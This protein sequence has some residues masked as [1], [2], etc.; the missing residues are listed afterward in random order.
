MYDAVIAGAGPA[1][2]TFAGKL[3]EAGYK[4]LLVDLNKKKNIG[5]KICGDALSVN[6]LNFL[7]NNFG[8]KLTKEVIKTDINNSRIFSS[9]FKYSELKSGNIG[10]SVISREILGQE[11]INN[12]IDKG[13]ELLDSTSVLDFI[14]KNNKI[15]GIK[16]SNPKKKEIKAELIIDATGVSS[17]LRKNLPQNNFIENLIDKKDIAV[18]HRKI[19]KLENFETDNKTLNF[20]FNPEKIKM[21]YFWIFP[22]GDSI[23][24]IGIGIS[25]NLGI[26][27]KKA[28]EDFSK[29]LN[30]KEIKVF[31]E[32]G[33]AVPTRRP[34]NSLVY[35]NFMLI[36]DAG[37]VVNP[38][39]GGGI[40][41]AFES[42]FYAS[43]TALSALEKE[44]C[45]I[46]NLW[47]Y[48]Q[49]YMALFGKINARYD[50]I[51]IIAGSILNKEFNSI[52][53]SNLIDYLMNPKSKLKLNFN[54]LKLL[55]TPKLVLKLMDLALQSKRVG[56][57]YK[58][59]PKISDFDSWKQKEN[60][61]FDILDSKYS[62]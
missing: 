11:L 59:Y 50:V 60:K 49:N 9:D 32:G 2:S 44:N 21:G 42:S 39:H 14:F 46:E 23:F 52:I 57:I 19:V 5:H 8:I 36:G 54:S 40:G 3:A 33:G 12:A 22:K 15:S 4:T 35:N 20:Y 38:I 58:K 26:S 16:T 51:K 7:K 34:M 18:C 56:S 30:L 61:F 47:N 13:A 6:A 55:K 1:G 28:Y 31:S 29:Q 17:V 41:N 27:P 45:S 25:S 53:E 43:K 10:G 48:N 62:P 37:C 24:N